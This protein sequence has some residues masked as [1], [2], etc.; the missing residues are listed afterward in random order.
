[1]TFPTCLEKSSLFVYICIRK[2]Y[3]LIK[4][5]TALMLK[6]GNCIIAGKRKVQ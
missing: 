4:E 1:M 2:S 6:A 5:S 3:V